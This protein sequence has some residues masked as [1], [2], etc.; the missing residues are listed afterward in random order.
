MM[1]FTSAFSINMLVVEGTFTFNGRIGARLCIRLAGPISP[2]TVP[3]EGMDV[4]F[5]SGF[6]PVCPAR[7][8]A[9][10]R[11]MA[12]AH[13]F[14]DVGSEPDAERFQTLFNS[15]LGRTGSFGLAG[16]RA[17]AAL[18]RSTISIRSP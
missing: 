13:V 16:I 15:L 9:P 3:S 5:S 14:G 12:V 7:V 2:N 17:H 6:V 1:A 11:A 18:S 10:V 8:V 4:Q